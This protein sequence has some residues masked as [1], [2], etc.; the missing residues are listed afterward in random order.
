[1]WFYHLKMNLLSILCLSPCVWIFS[2]QD[3]RSG[4][5]TSALR[6]SFIH[7]VSAG[8]CWDTA[9]IYYYYG[10]EGEPVT[11]RA[12]F[13][14]LRVGSVPVF[15]KKSTHPPR[16]CSQHQRKTNWLQ[17]SRYL[18]ATVNHWKCFN[19]PCGR[20]FSNHN[21]VW[22]WMK[23]CMREGE[24]LNKVSAVWSEGFCG[25]QVLQ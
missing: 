6:Y 17:N 1:M 19:S 18:S 24:K 22:L 4:Q 8:K 25:E 3:T 21:I 20:C 14:C 23:L 11:S 2:L 10:N 5:I 7:R 15:W 13:I 12:V 16:E 9:L